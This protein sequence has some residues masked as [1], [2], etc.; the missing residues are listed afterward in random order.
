VNIYKES[1]N[2]LKDRRG[3]KTTTTTTTTRKTTKTTTKSTKTTLGN[4][5]CGEECKNTKLENYC[6]KYEC[7]TESANGISEE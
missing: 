7:Y 4:L 6:T 5:M 1:N 3:T 2:K